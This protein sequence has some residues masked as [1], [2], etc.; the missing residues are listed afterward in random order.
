MLQQGT[1]YAVDIEPDMVRYL[2]ER[3]KREGLQNLKPIGGSA[4]DARPPAKVDLILLVD[5]YHHIDD[6]ERYFAS[7]PLRSSPA[8]GLR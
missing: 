8:A 5:V 1:V 2:G 7:S 3:A 6:R 4:D